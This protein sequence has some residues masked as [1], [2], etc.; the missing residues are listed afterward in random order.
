LLPGH[1]DHAAFNLFARRVQDSFARGK[2]SAR[3]VDADA[4]ADDQVKARREVSAV[5]DR[6]LSSI[7]IAAR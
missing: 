3:G 1:N 2:G 5:V 4:H 7:G 6:L